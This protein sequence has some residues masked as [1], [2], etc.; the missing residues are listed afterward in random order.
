M[1]RV[2]LTGGIGSGKS[3]VADMFS[4][5]NIAV[6]DTDLIAHQISQP[7]GP[8]YAAIIDAFGPDIVADDQTIDRKKLAR[9]VFNSAEKK[10]LLEHI[11]HPLIWLIVEQQVSTAS[12]P[13]C[14]IVVP[15]LFEGNHQSRFNATLAV[16]CPD[17]LRIDRVIERDQRSEDDIEAIMN[18]QISSDKRNQ[19]ADDVISNN[20]T[21]DSL[22]TSIRQLHEKYLSLANNSEAI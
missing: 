9:I 15:L 10:R 7:D 5:Y 11:I 1:F 2:G 4:K 13:Y 18:H 8:A 14:I 12:S 19:L 21:L 16:D 17:K 22:Q 20:S 3:T 6:I